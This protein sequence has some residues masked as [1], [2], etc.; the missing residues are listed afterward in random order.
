MQVEDLTGEALDYWVAMAMDRDAPR[1]DAS[2]CTVAGE[3]GGAP[4]PFAPSSSWADGG[5]IVERLPFAAFER[6]GARGPWR[7][8]LHR[9]VPAAGE[10]CTFNQ[11]GPTLLVAAM[12]TLVAST[13]GDDVPDLDMTRPRGVP[14]SV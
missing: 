8:V 3:Q 6:D 9:A 7:A 1:V 5:P 11:S 12:R 14:P 13:F 4:V 10:R 2:G